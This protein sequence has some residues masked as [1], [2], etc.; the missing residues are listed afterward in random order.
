MIRLLQYFREAAN[1][2]IYDL[3]Y[4]Y[5]SEQYGYIHLEN[6][7][8]LPKKGV[9]VRAISFV[10]HFI[11]S[12]GKFRIPCGPVVAIMAGSSPNQ[13]KALRPIEQNLPNSLLMGIG[14]TGCKQ[15]PVFLAYLCSLPFFPAIVFRLWKAKGYLRLAHSY[16]FDS[17][18]LTYGAYVASR[19][20]L[21]KTTP[22][23]VL[24][25]NDH[26]MWTRVLVLAAKAAGIKTAYLQHATVREGFP[27]LRFDMA[28]L[29]GMDAAKKYDRAGFS[30]TRVYLVGL[31]KFDPYY[32]RINKKSAARAVGICC[33][34]LD[35]EQAVIELCRDVR[36]CFPELP[37]HFRP[38]PQDMQ[39]GRASIWRGM[40]Q[41]L[42][43]TLSDSIHQNSFEYLQ[44]VDA[45]LSASSGILLEAAMM[46][47]FP[48]YFDFAP[49]P[50]DLYDFVRNGLV[51]RC[52]RDSHTIVQVLR[53]LALAKPDVRP[54]GKFYC[55]TIGTQYDDKSSEL[56]CSLV[57]S[58]VSG[59]MPG[60]EWKRIETLGNMEAF[61]L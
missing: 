52:F 9:L 18:W 41:E 47:V 14:V 17:Y 20:V 31:A 25:S 8:V 54:R 59:L 12:F 24:V 3:N 60:Q 49:T 4:S 51:D 7:D 39:S 22:G 57:N 15:F 61:D 30:N 36:K 16:I 55:S 10:I 34:T 11:I 6:K 48:I 38:H 37:I 23:V 50:V 58:I 27:P 19:I 13:I 35:P 28:M 5:S 29:D 1:L 2:D 26:V 32:S 56:V 53:D 40:V 33:G 21:Q 46:N 44:Q 43:F 45:I 42:N